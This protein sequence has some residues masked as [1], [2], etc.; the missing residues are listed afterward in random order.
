[1]SMQRE[2]NVKNPDAR[3]NPAELPR[4]EGKTFV[5]TGGHAGIGYFISEQLASTGATVV[6]ASRS[7]GKARNEGAQAGARG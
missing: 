3:W 6:M 7:E 2:N 1:M 4:A 5:V